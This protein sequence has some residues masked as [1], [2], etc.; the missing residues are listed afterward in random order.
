[1]SAK[2][3][4]RSSKRRLRKGKDKMTEDMGRKNR[5]LPCLC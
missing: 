3:K 5:A 1:M 4:P 2:N